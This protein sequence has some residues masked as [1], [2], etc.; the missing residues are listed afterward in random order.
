MTNIPDKDEVADS[1][2]A[3][4]NE[5]NPPKTV[6]NTDLSAG[7]S[8]PANVTKRPETRLTQPVSG[9]VTGVVAA[10]PHPGYGPTHRVLPS[11]CWL[12][13]RSLDQDGYGYFRRDGR[14]VRA[15][16][17]F[18]E[19][20]NGPVP[21]GMELDHTC[22]NRACVNPDH[23]EPVTHLENCRRGRLV[24]TGMTIEKAREARQLRAEGVSYAD[25]SARLNIGKSL[26][27][28]IVTNRCWKE[29]GDAVL[30]LRL[31]AGRG[32]L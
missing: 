19:R 4:P 28:Q 3:G 8:F 1:N 14:H 27:A 26:V 31:A 6:E 24:K 20:E 15:H 12:W 23:L 21:E 13:D 11:P 2:S 17:H 22:R 9:V 29:E 30:R 25:I 16:I 5:E 18:Y 32:A 10:A 7:S